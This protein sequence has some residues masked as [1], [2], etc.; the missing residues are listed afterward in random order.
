MGAAIWSV[1]ELN[2]AILCSSLP[3]LRP[4]LAR[5]MPGMSSAGDARAG[6]STGDRHEM[7]GRITSNP[8]GGQTATKSGALSKKR[9]SGIVEITDLVAARK[10]AA[11]DNASLPVSTDEV[12][13]AHASVTT[14]TLHS[15]SVSDAASVDDDRTSDDTLDLPMQ[16]TALPRDNAGS[17]VA[18]T[19]PNAIRGNTSSALAIARGPYHYEGGHRVPGSLTAAGPHGAAAV[20]PKVFSVCEAVPNGERGSRDDSAYARTRSL[21]GGSGEPTDGAGRSRILVTTEMKVK[22]EGRR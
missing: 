20:V 14:K 6:Q 9:Q 8:A 17:A 4:L 11:A 13:A 15:S 7:Y 16:R 3:T 10:G 12:S 19:G 18:A 5:F 21:S 2:C 22:A 1:V